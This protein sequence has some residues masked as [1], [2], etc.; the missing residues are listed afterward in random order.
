MPFPPNSRYAPV[1]TA[2]LAAPDGRIITYLERRFLPPPGSFALLQTYVVVQGDRLDTV[3]ARFLSDPTLFWRLCDA[4]RAMR[5]G[6][7]TATIGRRLRITLPEGI[8]GVP[9][10]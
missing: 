9:H 8:P 5:P 7:L 3:T 4:N 10:A 2:Q 6:E 1:S